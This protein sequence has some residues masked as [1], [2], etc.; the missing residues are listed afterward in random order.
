MSNKYLSIQNPDFSSQIIMESS[1]NDIN[2][3]EVYSLKEKL[4]MRDP[5]SALPDLDDIAFMRDLKLIKQDGDA[6]KL[7]IAD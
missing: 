5:K 4:R 3:L 2:K 1:E 6:Y 7:T